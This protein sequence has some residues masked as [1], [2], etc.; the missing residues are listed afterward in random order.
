M[1]YEISDSRRVAV[2][3]A[4]EAMA[5]A[6][7]VVL[8]THVN[9]DGDGAGSEAALL[10][11][12]RDMGVEGWV[13][14]PTPYPDL[15]RFLVHD[16]ARVLEAS[17]E[18]ATRRCREADLC[19]VVDTAEKAR[20]GRVNPMVGHLPFLIVDHHPS[21]PD[22]IVGVSLRDP[23]AAATGEL[24]FDLVWARGGPWTGE[25]VDGLYVAV[26][27][28]TGSF[29]FSNAT[30]GAHRVAAELVRRG[31]S[32]DGLYRRVFGQ[33]PVRRLHLLERVLGSL[34]VSDGGEVAWMTVPANVF[35]DLNCR[36][37]DLEG[38]V[39]YPRGVEGV[40]VGLLFREIEE[41]HV[42]VSLRSNQ[43][44]DV[45]A[46]AREF[47][48][49]GHVRA[50]GALVAGSVEEVREQVVGRAAEVAADSRLRAARPAP[51]V[52]E[53]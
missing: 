2:D 39:D 14:N 42:K 7:R 37:D 24:V 1:T 49:G 8:T 46:L 26:M 32:P 34:E 40:E 45:N 52:V 38:F 19:I 23:S 12:L 43:R 41:G 47:G 36:S 6:E 20:I 3:V 5:S 11:V 51:E 9:A 28:D 50:A 21:G 27:T 29:R 30:P 53:P 22:S 25:L 35:R 4:L 33:M 17:G 15:Y 13:V 44:V 10:A 48:G 31:A 18:E 16:D